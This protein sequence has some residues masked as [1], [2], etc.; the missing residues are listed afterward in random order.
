MKDDRINAFCLF[1]SVTTRTQYSSPDLSY[2]GC[3]GNGLETVSA[4]PQ[5]QEMGWP[6]QLITKTGPRPNAHNEV[7]LH[8]TVLENVFKMNGRS[9]KSACQPRGM[10]KENTPLVSQWEVTKRDQR[11]GATHSE[12]LLYIYIYIY[13]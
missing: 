4:K 10:T 8:K 7:A 13:I 11:S 6:N 5:G 9:I 1:L 12:A 2:A 3:R